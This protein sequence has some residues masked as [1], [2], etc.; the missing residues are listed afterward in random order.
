MPLVLADQ[1]RR[2]LVLVVCLTPKIV[3]GVFCHKC[4][5]SGKS[6]AKAP[7][8]QRFQPSNAC[9]NGLLQ[10]RGSTQGRALQRNKVLK[11]RCP[12]SHLTDSNRP[13]MRPGVG[14]FCSSNIVAS[15]HRPHLWRPP[16]TSRFGELSYS[17][18][19]VQQD[20]IN[21]VSILRS[22]SQLGRHKG[23]EQPGK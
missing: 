19:I 2:R 12:A 20:T 21:V 6:S 16:Y 14:A 9:R 8:L 5:G 1:S 13:S 18:I 4:S 23:D 15:P 22:G 17:F 11:K 3:K 7:P 10:V